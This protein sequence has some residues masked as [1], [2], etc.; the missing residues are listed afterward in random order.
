MLANGGWDLIK[1]LKGLAERGV[2]NFH[3]ANMRILTSSPVSLLPTMV[4]ATATAD[5]VV[6]IIII[7]III[8]I[9]IQ[10]HSC[11]SYSPVRVSLINH[12]R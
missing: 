6:V 7:I 2:K 11:T 5:Y 10:H 1:R 3:L 8:I 12:S 4:T 9:L